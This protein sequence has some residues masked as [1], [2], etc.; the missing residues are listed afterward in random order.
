MIKHITQSFMIDIQEY[1]AGILCGNIVHEKWVNDRLIDLDSEAIDLGCYFEYMLTLILTGK[2]SLPRNGKIP[3]PVLNQNGKM[4]ADYLRVQTNIDRV[5]RYLA[6]M[7]LQVKQ[8][9]V[10]LRDGNYEGTI[11]LICVC[12]KEIEFED[13][14]TWSIGQEII[15]DLKYSGLIDDVW[16]KFG[17]AGMLKSGPHIQKD[18]H[19]VQAVQ[20]HYVGK[21][22]FYFLIVHPKNDIAILMLH[23]PVTQEMINQHIEKGD[24]LFDF[25]KFT[26]EIGFEPRPEISKCNA[27]PLNGECKDKHTFPHPKTVYL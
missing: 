17:W 13:G 26:A 23:V 12:T 2:G 21:R 16:N 27:C 25:F 24:D 4:S 22:L 10:K 19:G 15:I 6:E 7:G 18:L 1:M 8:A 11:D 20:Y 9:G 3:L 14:S 5:I